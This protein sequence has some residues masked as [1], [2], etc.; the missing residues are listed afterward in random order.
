MSAPQDWPEISLPPLPHARGLARLRL[1]PGTLWRLGLP[2]LARYGRHRLRKGSALPADAPV[3][4]P[5]F[6]QEAAGP[7]PGIDWHGAAPSHLPA[8][9]VPTA[10][11]FDIRLL[12]ERA[13]L[14]DLPAIAPPAAEALVRSFVA[15]N[16]PYRGPHWACGQEASIRLAHLL[17]AAT[18]PYRPG[19]LALVRLHRDRIAATL[20]YAVAQDNNHATSEAAGLWL[21][22]V[23]LGEAADAARGRALLESAVRR[24][25]T[26]GGDFSQHSMRYQLAAL[27]MAAFAQAF[28]RLAMA[29]DV[30]QRLAV[31]TARLGELAD[32]GS[33]RPWRMGHDDSSRFLAAPLDDLR[34]ALARAQAAFGTAGGTAAPDFL[35]LAHGGLRAMLRVP[36]ISFR[37]AQADALHLEVWHR[38]QCLLGDAGS[39]LYNFSADPSAPDLARTAAHNTIAFDDDDQMPRLSRFLYGAWLRPRELELNPMRM[40]AGY[41]DWRGRSHT[42][43]VRREAHTLHVEDAFAGR[44]TRATLRWRLP[45]AAWRIDGAAA[46]GP[47][48]IDIAGAAGLRLVRLPFAP[49][50]GSRTTTPALEA[51]ADRPGTLLT[52]ITLADSAGSA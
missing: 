27:E 32:P 22:G 51:W 52:T 17:A 33:G 25:F 24:L 50:Y 30:R 26:A 13:R 19:L 43:T 10:G 8:L 2:A 38:D 40:R 28:A 1:L 21:A 29:A 39:A 20:D 48:R 41:R 6:L 49:R 9:S 15:A 45:E 46:L 4:E 35:A 18:P 16:P 11:P 36:R 37:P 34:P 12:W 44:F 31:A 42:R 14:V 47:F 23:A 3:P 5:P 7:D